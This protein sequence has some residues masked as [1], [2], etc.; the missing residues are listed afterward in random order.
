MFK[1]TKIGAVNK[2]LLSF[3]FVLIFCWFYAAIEPFIYILT[4][5]GFV[6]DYCPLPIN[7][8]I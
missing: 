1:N 8:K 7:T 4:G 5:W 6:Y 2:L 3:L